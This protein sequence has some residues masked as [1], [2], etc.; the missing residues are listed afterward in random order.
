MIPHGG[1]ADGHVRMGLGGAIELVHAG[2]AQETAVV[3][4]ATRVYLPG[5]AQEFTIVNDQVGF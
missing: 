2:R 5:G 4:I 1:V 3:V